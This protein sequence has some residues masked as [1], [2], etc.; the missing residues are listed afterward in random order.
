L[1]ISGLINRNKVLTGRNGTKYK[2]AVSIGSCRKSKILDFYPDISL[3][4]SGIPIVNCSLKRSVSFI[5]L[6]ING[7][8]VYFAPLKPAT[9][10]I[11]GITKIQVGDIDSVKG[12]VKLKVHLTDPENMHFQE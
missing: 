10:V 1:E 12:R 11:K 7:V 3:W 8:I 4:K 2:E 9:W 6:N 5:A